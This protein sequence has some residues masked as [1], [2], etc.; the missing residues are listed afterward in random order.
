MEQEDKK[1]IPRI[2]KKIPSIILKGFNLQKFVPSSIKKLK[3]Q[4]IYYKI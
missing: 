4:K 1:I 3:K 2:N